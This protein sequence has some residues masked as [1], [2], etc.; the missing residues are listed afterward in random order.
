MPETNYFCGS[1]LSN[2]KKLYYEQRT[3][4]KFYRTSLQAF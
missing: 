3:G 1:K 2:A 4:F